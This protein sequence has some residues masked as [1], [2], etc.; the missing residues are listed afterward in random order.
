MATWGLKC[1]NLDRLSKTASVIFSNFTYGRY[2]KLDVS[3]GGEIKVYPQDGEP[4]KSNSLSAGTSDQLYIALRIAV[5][6]LLAE[7]IKLPFLFD[8]SFVNFDEERLEAAKL[9][10]TKISADRQVVLLSHNDLF[11]N[12]GDKVIK[13]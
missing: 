2:R 3:S 11:Q 1:T 13:I 12:W 5:A 7:D 8:D 10:L 9:I 4:F 6:D